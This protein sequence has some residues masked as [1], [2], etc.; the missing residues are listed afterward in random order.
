LLAPRPTPPP[1]W[2]T[3][4]YRLSVTAYLIYWQLPSISEGRFLNRK[5][6]EDPCRG[7][8]GPT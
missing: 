6:E 3:T 5:T 1:S 7:D 4:P 2:R 8:W